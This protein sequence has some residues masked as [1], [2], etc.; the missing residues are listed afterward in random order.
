[1]PRNKTGRPPLTLSSLPKNWKTTML[2]LM[3]QGASKIEVM[4]ALGFRSKETFRA[5]AEREPEFMD[6][7]Q[8]GEI[9]CE[10]WWEQQGRLGL[11]VKTFNTGLWYANM[12]NRFG[13]RDK[14]ETEVS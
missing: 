6:A 14:Q 11:R 8:E 12:K 1:M 9:L 7:L 2:D 13:W 5:L 10:V 3:R 4:A